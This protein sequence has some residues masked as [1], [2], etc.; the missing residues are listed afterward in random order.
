MT[1]TNPSDQDIKTI[2][3]QPLTIA[4]VICSP[5]PNRD[6]YRIAGR[7]VEFGYRMIPVNPR[8]AGDVIHG[9]LCYGQLSDIPEPVDIVDIFRRSSHVEPI[10]DEAIAIQAQILWLQLGVIHEAGAQRAQQ[11]GLTV[12]MDRCTS[13]DYRRLIQSST[14]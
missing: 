12:V 11:A 14:V 4:V 1:F 9:Q 5:T 6:S 7:L 10:I 3:E 8:A 2:L 13:R